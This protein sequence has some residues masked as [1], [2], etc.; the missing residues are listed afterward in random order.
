MTTAP[1]PPLR[2][3][4]LRRRVAD[5]DRAVDFYCGALGFF[6]DAPAPPPPPGKRPT[7]IPPKAERGMRLRLGDELL[8]LVAPPASAD[9]ASVPPDTRAPVAIQDPGFR[10]L[11]IVVSDMDLAFA[12]LQAFAPRAISLGG[13]VRLPQEAGGV[14]AFKFRDP[15]GHPLELIQFPDGAGPTR[16]HAAAAREGAGPTL[17]ID[18]C[19]IT[20]A[21]V[22]RSVAWHADNLGWTVV[23]RHVNDGPGQDALDGVPGTVVDVVTLSTTMPGTPHLELLGY[24]HPAVGPRTDA[25][26]SDGGSRLLLDASGES[27][28]GKRSGGRWTELVDPDGHVTL[29]R[30]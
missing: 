12:R 21:D 28:P 2:L 1:P 25:P 5:L 22:A 3:I 13:P 24:R 19:A 16:W 6:R 30:R 27:A 14:L 9:R 15:D 18:H 7:Q 8:E 26:G 11:A 4:G 23:A 29:L 20:V 17:G 10:H